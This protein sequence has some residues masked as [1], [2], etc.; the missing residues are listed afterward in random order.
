MNKEDLVM[1]ISKKAEI[2]QIM[3]KK[4]IE[5][6]LE[7]IKLNVAKGEKITL[8]GFGTFKLQHRAERTARIINENKEIRIPATI[9]PVFIPSKRFKE[10]VNNYKPKPGYFMGKLL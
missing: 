3:S 2:T 10:E 9:L 8:Q 6:L 7:I 5:I 4:I 1:E